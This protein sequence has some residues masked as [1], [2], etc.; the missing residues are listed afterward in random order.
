MARTKASGRSAA[1]QRPSKTTPRDGAVTTEAPSGARATQSS[2]LPSWLLQWRQEFSVI[3]VAVALAASLNCLAN[4]FAADDLQQVLGSSAIRSLWNLPYA[5][6]SSVWTFSSDN[7]VFTTDKYYRPLFSVLFTLGYAV[8]GK[9]AWGWHLIGIVLDSAVAF[10]VFALMK[11]ITRSNWMA[12]AVSVLF[13]AHPVHAESV[14]WISGMTDPLMALFVLPCL[15]LYIRYR[16]NGGTGSLLA[17]LLLALCALLSKETAIVLPVLIGY[18]EFRHFAGEGREARETGAYTGTD[19]EEG[20][21]NMAS[22][23]AAFAMAGLFTLPVAAYL[24][25]RYV[26][27]GGLYLTS[28]ALLPM[29]TALLTMPKIL[30]KY[31]LLTFVPAGYSYMHN[32]APVTSVLSLGLIV[33]V[34][35][36]LAL[37][38]A[39]I[40]SKSRLTEF[41]A[42]F[43]LIWLIPPIAAI[44]GFDPVFMVQDRYLYLSSIGGPLI[45]ALGLRWL[46]DFRP[47]SAWPRSLAAIAAASVLLVAITVH[48]RQNRIWSDNI[49][50]FESCVVQDPALAPARAALGNSYFQEGRLKQAEAAERDA[51][52]ADSAAPDPYMYLSSFAN[53]QG[54]LDQAIAYLEDGANQV[55]PLPPTTDKLATMYLNL[56]MLYERKK[57]FDRA[58]KCIN[59]SIGLWRRPVAFYYL[60]VLYLDAGR[61]EQARDVLNSASMELPRRFAPVH[62]KLAL[63]YQ[64][65]G[66]TMRARS[67]YQRFVDMAPDGD[68][69]D[70]AAR[71]LLQ[72]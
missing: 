47:L 36:I 12:L 40:M 25:M 2:R 9:S 31:I 11:N 23:S 53:S 5:F 59:R 27:L 21:R 3:P 70:E 10:L 54:R 35:V 4:G 64:A 57:D 45:V 52:E 32:I 24:L 41:A 17:S 38:V 15:L 42:G 60:G 29:R 33:P 37:A 67:E 43:F 68:E 63:T 8:F 16:K 66:D 39:V 1:A 61:Y 69:K 19:V 18:L 50:L 51:K 26:A 30:V 13:A 65:L 28:Q 58:E 34:A 48:V 14:A 71:R 7:V 6:T 62:A 22:L 55:S 72:L 20:S 44:P 46:W 56:G 49:G